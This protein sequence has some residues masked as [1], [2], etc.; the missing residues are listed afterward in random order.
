MSARER[1]NAQGKRDVAG[2]LLG[3]NGTREDT[4]GRMDHARADTQNMDGLYSQA[5]QNP[6]SVQWSTPNESAKKKE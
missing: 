1:L 3:L 6:T 5:N 4:V 2:G